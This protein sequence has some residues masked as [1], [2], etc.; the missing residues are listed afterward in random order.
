MK[1]HTKERKLV[2]EIS[3][4]LFSLSRH[5]PA[6]LLSC[7]LHESKEEKKKT[8]LAIRKKLATIHLF[9]LFLSLCIHTADGMEKK[10]KERKTW[11]DD[12]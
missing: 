7:V 6:S 3:E 11:T 8:Y 1:V 10:R 2:E 4:I 12:E 9:H 5:S